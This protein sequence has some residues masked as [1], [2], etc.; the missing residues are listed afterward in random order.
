MKQIK[1]TE[2]LDDYRDTGNYYAVDGVENAPSSGVAFLEV[3]S[4]SQ[5]RKLQRYTVLGSRTV[6]IRTV[7]STSDTKWSSWANVGLI[8]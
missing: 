8:S 4:Y 3:L 1:A 6:Y 7:A 5:Y 2:N